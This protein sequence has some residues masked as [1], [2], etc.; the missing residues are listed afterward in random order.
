MANIELPLP[1]T[2]HVAGE[3]PASKADPVAV[4]DVLLQPEVLKGLPAFPLPVALHWQPLK[5]RIK[6]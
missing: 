4:R 2:G 1:V 5:V 3:T 6:W